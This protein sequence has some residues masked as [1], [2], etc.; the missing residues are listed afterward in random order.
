M[1][2]KNQALLIFF[3]AVMAEYLHLLFVNKIHSFYIRN[4]INTP[5]YWDD[6]IYHFCNESLMLTVVFLLAYNLWKSRAVK[7]LMSGLFFW[8]FI[9]W[10]EILLHLAKISDIR[11]YINDGSWLQISTCLTISLLVLFGNKKLAS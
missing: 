3:L 2:K 4:G 7:A 5:I 8:F 9:E 6:M 10:V 1:S 11:L